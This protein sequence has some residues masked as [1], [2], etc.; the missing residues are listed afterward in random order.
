MK[1][2]ITIFIFSI[3]LYSYEENNKINLIK[4]SQNLEEIRCQTD[5][6]TNINSDKIKD[7]INIQ[8]MADVVWGECSICS[9]Q[10]QDSIF[11]T[12]VNRSHS[13]YYPSN[14]ID[15]IESPNQYQGYNPVLNPNLSKDI[16]TRAKRFYKENKKTEIIF[17]MSNYPKFIRKYEFVI[18]KPSGFHHNFYAYGKD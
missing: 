6:Q 1:L 11:Q 7:S 10:E 4:K 18:G 14:I 3:A 8:A 15:V 16:K 9:E 2:L 17:F 12:I 13:I 5:N